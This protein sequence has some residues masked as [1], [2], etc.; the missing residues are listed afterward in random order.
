[1]VLKYHL[2]GLQDVFIYDINGN[3]KFGGHCR[4]LSCGGTGNQTCIFS[5]LIL[6]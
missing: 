2:I 6:N 1:M 3:S 4:L 5:D